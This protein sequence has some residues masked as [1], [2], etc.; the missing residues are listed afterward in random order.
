MKIKYI[1]EPENVVFSC[2]AWRSNSFWIIAA[3]THNLIYH[4][5]YLTLFYLSLMCSLF[6]QVW[7]MINYRMTFP[8]RFFNYYNVAP[9]LWYQSYLIIINRSYQAKRRKQCYLSSR[10]FYDIWYRL[11]VIFVWAP[12]EGLGFRMPSPLLS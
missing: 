8:V 11:G 5:F 2:G 12:C 10:Y 6:I 7:F 3:I 1:A 4:H 9:T